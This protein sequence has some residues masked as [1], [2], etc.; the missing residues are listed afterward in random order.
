[1]TLTV[2]AFV[3]FLHRSARRVRP[4]FAS[5]GEQPLPPPTPSSLRSKL[6]SGISKAAYYTGILSCITS[7]A[8]T[9]HL[10][11]EL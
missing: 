9:I 11:Y 7:V 5:P 8:A 2:F 4:A 3:T 10:S 1:M 6:E